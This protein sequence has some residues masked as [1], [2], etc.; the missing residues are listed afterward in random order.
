ME[1]K[2]IRFKD[3]WG[4]T[5][6]DVFR[7]CRA[8]FKYQFIDKL[9]SGNSSPALERGGQIHEDIENYI[10]GW[11]TTLGPDTENWKPA[12]DLLRKEDY[13]GEQAIGIAKDWRLLPDWFNPAT[14]L[15]VK[16]DTY[17]RKGSRLQVIDYKSGKYRVPSTDQVEL[18]SIAGLSIYPDLDEVEAEYWFID[19]G[20]FYKKVY[21]KAELVALRPKYEREAAAIYAEGQWSPMPSKEC[22]WCPYSKTKGGP[23]RY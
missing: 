1:T 15:R 20:D 22:R 13:H 9:P 3:P 17:Y 11:T 7:T 6:L 23:C 4:F 12:L 2:V 18:Y 16:M 8:K 10:N 14:W 21:T 5:K 19:T